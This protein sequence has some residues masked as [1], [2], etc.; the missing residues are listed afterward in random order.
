LVHRLSEVAE[1]IRVSSVPN[2]VA[3]IGEVVQW[4]VSNNGVHGG[5]LVGHTRVSKTVNRKKGRVASERAE[6]RLIAVALA[7][8]ASGVIGL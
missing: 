8:D 5:S 4:N 6:A 2:V 7:D 3:R 1:L